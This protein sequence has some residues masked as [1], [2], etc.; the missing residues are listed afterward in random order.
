MNAVGI[1]VS[2]GKSMVTV[3]RPFGEAVVSPF[4]VQHTGNELSEL[5]KT[6]KSING[7]TRVV[8]EYTGNYHTPTPIAR[9]LHDAGTYV[10]VLGLH[11]H[12]AACIAMPC[13]L[14]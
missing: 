10:A 8:M 3:M 5:A 13:Y 11:T 7:E 6:L 2:K 1:N 4:E 12:S 9:V 14:I